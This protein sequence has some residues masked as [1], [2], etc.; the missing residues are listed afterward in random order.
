MR[1][2][3]V[4]PI[5][6]ATGGTG[7]H[8]FPAEALSL[9]LAARGRRVVL[10]TDAR[11]AGRE[12]G[13][14]EQR[15]TIP[16]AG[17]AGRG[18]V[19]AGGA[20]LAIGRGVLEARAALSRLRACAVIGFG[21]YPAVAPVLGARMLGI[22]AVLHEQNA[23]LGRANR[24]L[25]RWASALALSFGTTSRLP[26]GVRTVPTGNPVR[27]GF[28]PAPY[29]PPD[30]GM[31]IL[32]IGGSLGARAL[33]DVV[34]PAIAGL[35]G[36]RPKVVQQC[37]PEDLERVRHA[38]AQA[39]IE[40]EL[41]TFFPDIPRRLAEAQLVIARA[42]AST[43]AEL[44]AVGRPAVLVPLPHAID[45]HQTENARALGAVV[46]PEPVLPQTLR[47]TIERMLPELATIAAQVAAHGRPDATSSLADLVE[48]FVAQDVPV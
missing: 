9:E 46:M 48:S 34:P 25:A 8:F 36:P 35:A 22:P 37:R 44:A 14:F 15:M 27:P 43:V 29:T 7:G 6:I 45:D 13:A 3:E 20:L 5:V 19:R 12:G 31:R 1:A 23:V 42:G 17:I 40:A 38:Y 21:G 16:G 28:A 47:C 33:S 32:V 26:T 11:T 39:G 41:A 4:R 18:A 2:P 10:M 30:G 24:F